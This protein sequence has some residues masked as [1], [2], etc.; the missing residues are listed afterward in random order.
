MCTYV[1]SFIIS[2]AIDTEKFNACISVFCGK[3]GLVK[4]DFYSVRPWKLEE[5]C[6]VILVYPVIV[7]DYFLLCLS[8]IM[9]VYVVINSY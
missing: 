6:D 9:F 3:N 1:S 2:G 7:T 8:L 5:F 4:G